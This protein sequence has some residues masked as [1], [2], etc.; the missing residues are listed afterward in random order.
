MTTDASDRM[1]VMER[2]G[3][4]SM[5]ET[6]SSK[7]CMPSRPALLSMSTC[8]VEDLKSGYKYTRRYR[9]SVPCIMMFALSRTATGLKHICYAIK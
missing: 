2:Q 3:M 9:F 1:F 6:Q 5:I 4:K 8:I 7:K